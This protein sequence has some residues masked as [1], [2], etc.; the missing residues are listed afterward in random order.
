MRMRPG[1]GNTDPP[2][3]IS[4]PDAST[5]GTEPEIVSVTI[6]KVLTLDSTSFKAE[7]VLS[8]QS[9][10]GASQNAARQGGKMQAPLPRTPPP[11]HHLDEGGVYNRDGVLSVAA[12][13]SISGRAKPETV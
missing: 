10:G 2:A 11:F 8:L 7:V 6:D 13:Y 12:Q 5:A 1:R 9:H 4:S 3:S